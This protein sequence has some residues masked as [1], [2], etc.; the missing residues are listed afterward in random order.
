VGATKLAEV[1][2]NNKWNESDLIIT[3]YVL[4]IMFKSISLITDPSEDLLKQLKYSMRYED[5]KTNR[6]TAGYLFYNLSGR[7]L[8]EKRYQKL[9]SD[10]KDTSLTTKERSVIKKSLDKVLKKSCKVKLK[11]KGDKDE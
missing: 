7:S 4:W 1:L 10:L 5:N 2:N 9:M 8:S 3:E 6:V 11:N